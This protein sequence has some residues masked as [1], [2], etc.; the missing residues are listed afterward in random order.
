MLRSRAVFHH[1]AAADAFHG[2]IGVGR[3]ALM[4][5]P[6]FAGRA[7]CAGHTLVVTGVELDQVNAVAKAVMGVSQVQRAVGRVCSS[8]H[9]APSKSVDLRT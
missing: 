5:T 9:G 6:C 1:A 7:H 4:V 2:F 3:G 8:A